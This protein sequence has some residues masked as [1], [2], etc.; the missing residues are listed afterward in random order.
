MFGEV[1]VLTLAEFLLA[2][3]GAYAVIRTSVWGT[4]FHVKPFICSVCMGYWVGMV[5]SFYFFKG[6][7]WYDAQV[8]ALLSAGSN[9]ILNKYVNGEN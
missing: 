5:L 3:F 6:C 4:R 9:W 1:A 7:H 2:S 8:Y